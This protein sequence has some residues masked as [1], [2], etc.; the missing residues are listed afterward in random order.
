MSAV[1]LRNEQRG[2]GNGPLPEID[3]E[4]RD[5]G[6]ART[7]AEDAPPSVPVPVPQAPGFVDIWV[8]QAKETWAQLWLWANK[9]GGL[10][11]DQPASLRDLSRYWW[12]APMAGSSTYLRWVQRVDGFTF[13]L[14]FTIIGRSFGWL[15]EKP[16][17]R[18]VT[19]F[20][21][22]VILRWS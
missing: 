14:L 20:V 17:R 12:E 8:D 1:P 19:L 9:D 5:A 15:G 11:T 22:F 10:L 2:K 13:G 6:D 7:R 16:I 3:A 18:L 4:L 21:L